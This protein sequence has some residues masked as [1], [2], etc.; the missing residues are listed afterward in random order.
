MSKFI[1]RLVEVGIEKEDSRGA[2]ALGGPALW[3]P[4][5]DFNFDDKIEKVRSQAGLGKLADSEEAFIVTKYGAGDLTMN[6]RSQVIG[7]F[8]YSMLGSLSTTGPTDTAAYTHSFTISEDNQH[9]SL[10]LYIKD[11][12][13]TEEYKLVMVNSLEFVVALD[14]LV[15]VTANFL[16]KKGNDY[17]TLTPSYIDEP[18]F[19]KKHVKVKVASDISGLSGASAL[20]LKSLRLTINQ[21]VVRDDGLGTA[22]PEDILNQQLSVEGEIVLDY[23]DET[24]KNYFRTPTDRAME[25][26]FENTDKLIAGAASTYPSLTFQLPKVDFHT[27]EPVYGLDE[28]VTQTL[29]FK[30][31]YDVDNDQNIIHSCELVNGKTSY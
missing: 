23:E 17:S 7:Y 13:T 24:W 5:V 20:S 8:L 28:I 11:K 12:N 26:K 30:A 1:G 3:I 18:M 21:N 27:W 9:Q 4:K 25:I 10:V 15:R 31:S 6:L 14:E 2:G 19:T 29:S 16:S 22:E